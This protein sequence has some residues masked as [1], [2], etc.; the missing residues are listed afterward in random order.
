M[1]HP[2]LQIIK[3]FLNYES[4]L[5]YRNY[6]DETDFS[7]ELVV[8]LRAVDSWYTTNNVNLSPESLAVE[9]YKFVIKDKDFYVSIIENLKTLEIQDNVLSLLDKFK[10]AKIC[11]ELANVAFEA[12]TG[13]KPFEKV[14]EIVDRLDKTEEELQ[15]DFVSENLDDILDHQVLVPGLRWRL[16]CLNKAAGSLRKGDFVT[17]FARPEV[18]KTSFLASE[19]TF[20]AK[21]AEG[22][23]LWFN[24]EEQGSKV[25][26]RLYQAALGAT[27]ETLLQKRDK[28]GEAFLQ[29][30]GN[31]VKIIDRPVI[32]KKFVE[33]LCKQHNPSL[34]VFDQLDKVVGFDADRY[35]LIMGAIYQWAR[36][37]AKTY[38]PVIGVC[39]A[40]GSA[41]NV[42][43]LNMGHMANSKTSKAAEA[44]L[45]IGI[46]AKSDIG[47]EYNRY[48]SICKNKLSG[49][50][51]SDERLRHGKFEVLIDPSIARYK[52]LDLH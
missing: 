41:E 28:A 9:L 29:R 32:N 38:C 15:V 37:L 33:T 45:I 34:I 49:D 1:I 36:E 48:L 26:F 35:D 40:D 25:M 4:Y 39:Q 17:I 12:S 3:L 19:V 16:S 18:G 44:D 8:L 6:V 5:T 13:N 24:N 51:D 43:W 22:T 21:Q 2:E 52:E 14:L 11:R 42:D 50:A 23:I 20:M 31:R 7:K 47:Y 30:T 27:K 46:G 10:K